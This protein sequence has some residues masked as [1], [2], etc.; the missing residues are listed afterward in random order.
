M[1]IVISGGGTGGHIYP[2]ITIANQIKSMEPTAEITFVGTQH[3]LEKNIVPRYGYPLRFITVAG[4]ERHLS[5][6]TVV[7]AMKLLVGLKDARGLLKEIKPD[8]VIGT[9]GY[10]CG[11]VLFWAAQMGIPT[12]IQEQN[13]MPGVTNKIL[14][15]FVDAICLGY[16]E[17]AKYFKGKARKI[18]TGNPV[19]QEILNDEREEGIQKF[20]LDKNK[21]TVLVFG[22][23]RG[24]RSINTAM[25]EVEK[26]LA[27]R[28]DVQILHATGELDYEKYKTQ[29]APGVLDSANIKILPYIHEMPLALSVADIA[30]ARA[31][32][33]GLAELLVKGI[34]SILIP[35]PYATANH[36][37]YNARAVEAAGAAEVVLDKD[38]TGLIL[39]EKIEQLLTKPDTLA[40]MHTAAQKISRPLA[41]K[42]IAQSALGLVKRK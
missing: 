12:C 2:A 26:A 19:R 37:E 27:G 18:F 33:I 22:G 25:L 4:F 29:L 28:T 32:A 34:P 10:V 14:S 16:N 42:E 20:S 15:H 23:S 9:G 40:A 39:R 3:G 24:A 41:A 13:A 17:G 30:I 36:Q 21:K 5:V 1:K 7:S 31:G 8:L 6:G 11:P 35:Y 38:L